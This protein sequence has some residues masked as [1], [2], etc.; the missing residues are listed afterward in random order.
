MRLQDVWLLFR[1]GRRI[2]YR[3]L[4]PNQLSLEWYLALWPKEC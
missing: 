4:T 1:E 3:G 2:A